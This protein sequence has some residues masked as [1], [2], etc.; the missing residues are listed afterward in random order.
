MKLAI[1]WGLKNTG[2]VWLAIWL[3]M[4]GPGT[5]TLVLST[6][7]INVVCNRGAKLWWTEP[8]NNGK[9]LGNTQTLCYD[10]SSLKA[11]ETDGKRHA[12]NGQ[13]AN[14]TRVFLSTG[15][16]EKDT[17]RVGNAY[18]Q[19]ARQLN[20]KG[21]LNKSLIVHRCW[22]GLIPTLKKNKDWWECLWTTGK[23]VREDEE[24]CRN[25][26]EREKTQEWYMPLATRY[27][28]PPATNTWRNMMKLP[29]HT[30]KA[31]LTKQRKNMGT[32]TQQS[33]LM[34]LA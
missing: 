20:N 23:W 18:R 7:S 30:M 31:T 19:K 15:Q 22:P 32:N 3:P 6:S 10:Y 11:A 28:K 21:S 17:R 2:G 27:H 29:F 4:M 33:Y 12:I 16:T 25:W 26:R 1:L 5:T 8:L 24:R 34:P 14:G 9:T 13:K